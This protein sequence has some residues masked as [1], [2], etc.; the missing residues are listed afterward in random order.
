VVLNR[1][2]QFRAKASAMGRNFDVAIFDVALFSSGGTVSIASGVSPWGQNTQPN[3]KARITY[4]NRL[5]SG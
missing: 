1:Q 2:R 3:R 5:I 4:C